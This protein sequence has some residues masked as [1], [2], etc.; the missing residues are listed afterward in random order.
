M[1][2]NSATEY[3]A[4][5]TYND[6][7]REQ[8]GPR[9]ISPEVMGQFKAQ[10]FNAIMGGALT[11]NKDL[12]A[13]TTFSKPKKIEIVTRT[14]SLENIRYMMTHEDDNDVLKAILLKKRELEMIRDNSV[15]PDA[16]V[17]P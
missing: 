14:E 6:H 1:A 16:P 13:W 15:T 10:A 8:M 2:R 3:D 5:G 11:I 4:L 12:A 9:N 17:I 7:T